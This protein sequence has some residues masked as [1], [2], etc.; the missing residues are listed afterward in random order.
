MIMGDGERQGQSEDSRSWSD[1]YYVL[2]SYHQC[3]MV[4]QVSC[5]SISHHSTIVLQLSWPLSHRYR[6]MLSIIAIL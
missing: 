6:A 3:V 1:R 5:Y 2:T 4:R